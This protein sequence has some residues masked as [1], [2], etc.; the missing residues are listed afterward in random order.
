MSPLVLAA[1]KT[2]GLFFYVM[3]YIN[4]TIELLK[5]Y[6]SSKSMK[7][8]LAVAIWIKMQH[9]NSVMW[10]VT[11]YKLRKGLHIGK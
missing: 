11:E 6:S 9:S 1:T 3:Q 10:N 5:T 2:L 8:L 4:V 7:E